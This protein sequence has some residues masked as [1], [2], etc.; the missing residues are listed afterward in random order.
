MLE[1][2]LEEMCP[3]MLSR[4]TKHDRVFSFEDLKVQKVLIT[5]VDGLIEYQLRVVL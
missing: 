1:K 3:G 4:L 5:L 2:W